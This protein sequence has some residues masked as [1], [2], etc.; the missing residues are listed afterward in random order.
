MAAKVQWKATIRR[1]I[2]EEFV[3]PVSMTPT[4]LCPILEAVLD[5][6]VSIPEKITQAWLEANVS[7]WRLLDVLEVYS[8]YEPA[9]LIAEKDPTTSHCSDVFIATCSFEEDS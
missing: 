4:E 2:E 9:R 1:T 3:I 6:D 5:H 7:P 8:G